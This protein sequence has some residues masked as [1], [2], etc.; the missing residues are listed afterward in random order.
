MAYRFNLLVSSGGDSAIS[1]LIENTIRSAG[2]VVTSRESEPGSDGGLEHWFVVEVAR[3]NQLHAIVSAVDALRG[4][5][6]MAVREPGRP[7]VGPAAR[8]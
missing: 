5:G 3:T 1:R 8:R 2:G 6:V 4:V 7:R